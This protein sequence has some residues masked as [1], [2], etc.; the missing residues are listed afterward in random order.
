[1]V[2]PGEAEWCLEIVADVLDHY[3]VKPATSVKKTK[4]AESEAQS[5]RQTTVEVTT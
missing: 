3:Y 1:M 4:R 5:S 2:E